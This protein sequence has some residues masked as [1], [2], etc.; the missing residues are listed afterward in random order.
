[1]LLNM[2]KYTFRKLINDIHLWLGIISGI[3][4][5]VVCLTGTILAFETELVL[6]LDK[7]DHFSKKTKE[8]LPYQ[9]IIN[10]FSEGIFS[11]I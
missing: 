5:F 11:H 2:R 9:D 7:Q 6:L 8:K 4:L 10:E 1:M 3:V